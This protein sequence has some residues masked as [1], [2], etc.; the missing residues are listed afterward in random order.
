MNKYAIS[1]SLAVLLTS[2]SGITQAE[3]STSSLA[4]RPSSAAKLA[5]QQPVSQER[6]ENAIQQM[7]MLFTGS[8][9]YKQI[10]NNNSGAVSAGIQEAEKL[11]KQAHQALE[12]NN[13]EDAIQLSN[14]AKE[15]FFNVTRQADSEGALAKKHASD[16]KH[17]LSSV[18]A[19]TTALE[20]VA[21]DAGK[22]P[23]SALKDIQGM[24]NEANGLAKKDKYV[25]G[26]KILDKAFLSLKIAID[27]IKEGT[28]VTAQKDTSPKGIYEYEVFRNDTYKSLIEMLMEEGRKLAIATDPDFLKDVKKGDAIRKEGIAMGEKARYGDAIKKLGESTSVYKHA[29]RLAGVPIID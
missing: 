4:T 25:D 12:N 23:E 9:A 8:S 21:T 5:Q 6:A 14:E 3:E 13:Y 22:N 15:S 20:Q 24:I 19:L 2:I 27:S 16:F 28:T 26:R 1:T 29:V 17:R 7:E 10:S 11:R 18:N